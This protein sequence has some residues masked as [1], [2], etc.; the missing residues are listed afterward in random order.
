MSGDPSAVVNTINWFQYVEEDSSE[1]HTELPNEKYSRFQNSL[2]SDKKDTIGEK[3]YSV[4]LRF[5]L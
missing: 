3:F 5:F 1:V 2:S 4:K